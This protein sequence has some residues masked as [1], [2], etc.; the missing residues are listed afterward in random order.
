MKRIYIIAPLALGL[1]SCHSTDEK[2]QQQ[3]TVAQTESLNYVVARTSDHT[4]ALLLTGKV[5]SNPNTTV[6]YKPLSEGIVSQCFF[7]V[8]DYVK[9][10]Q[11]LMTVQSTAFYE[12][13]NQLEASAGALKL[14][15]RELKRV[16]QMFEDGLLAEQSLIEAQIDSDQA[17]ALYSRLE[18]AIKMYGEA[19]G[20]GVYQVNAQRD[21]YI[22]TKHAPVHSTISPADE[23]YTLS[24]NDDLMIL[25]NVYATSVNDITVGQRVD[26]STPSL[27]NRTFKGK[28]VKMYPYIDAEEKVMKAQIEFDN[29]NLALKPDFMVDIKV[30]NEAWGQKVC[31]ASD[32]LVFDDK[33]YFALLKKSG[34][35]YKQPVEVAHHTR[36]YAIIES[37]IAVGDSVL[38]EKQLFYYA[39]L[40]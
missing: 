19:V 23:V 32:C 7:T 16:K 21:G 18:T 5:V 30:H 17:T 31:V 11:K 20:Q 38:A 40:K 10:G 33:Q 27:P 25:A 39:Q 12:L 4:E 34:K 15:E 37:G 6:V 24:P 13:Q 22:L 3:E 29:T 26:I 36:K 1:V 35:M 28:I 8:G 2:A 14:A 9:A